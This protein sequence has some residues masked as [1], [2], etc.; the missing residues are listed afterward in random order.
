MLSKQAE[1]QKIVH[2]QSITWGQLLNVIYCWWL[3]GHYLIHAI[4]ALYSQVPVKG[5]Y[6]KGKLALYGLYIYNG[7]GLD[8]LEPRFPGDD[9]SMDIFDILVSVIDTTP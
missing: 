1:L 3:K 4:V 8:R 7:R 6:F 2:N 5:L 9:S